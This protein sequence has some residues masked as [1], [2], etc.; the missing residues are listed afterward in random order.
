MSFD[1]IVLQTEYKSKV[2]LSESKV[3]SN[4]LTSK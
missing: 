1:Q 4:K 2:K 3:T